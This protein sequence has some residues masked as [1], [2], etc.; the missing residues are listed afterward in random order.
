MASIRSRQNGTMKFDTHVG[1]ATAT[2]EPSER[3]EANG[4]VTFTL[5]SRQVN[6]TWYVTL[7]KQVLKDALDASDGTELAERVSQTDQFGRVRT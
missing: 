4:M 7:S 3:D 1:N 2:I 6:R 5:W